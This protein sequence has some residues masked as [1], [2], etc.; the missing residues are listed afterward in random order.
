MTVFALYTC[1]QRNDSAVYKKAKHIAR[2]SSSNEIM[3]SDLF[4]NVIRS[5]CTLASID[6][7]KAVA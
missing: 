6:F 7:M 4:G 5:I 2:Q 3:K 1:K